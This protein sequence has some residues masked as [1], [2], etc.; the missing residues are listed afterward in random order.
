[1]SAGKAALKSPASDKFHDGRVRWAYFVIEVDG[2]MWYVAANTNP[3][4]GCNAVMKGDSQL[5]HF[6]SR[7]D[8]LAGVHTRTTDLKKSICSLGA[9]VDEMED[10]EFILDTS[11]AVGELNSMFHLPKGK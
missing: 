1:M 6:P 10:E 4:N 2:I 5:R 7:E 9:L 11:R 8:F 3:R